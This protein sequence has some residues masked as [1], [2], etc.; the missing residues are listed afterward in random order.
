MARHL[1]APALFYG[2]GARLSVEGLERLPAGPA[3]LVAN[4]QSIIDVPVLFRALP[5]GLHFIVK[6]ELRRVPFL[7]W[8]IAAT[9][10]IFV[11]RRAPA[12]AMAEMRRAAALLRGGATVVSFPEGTRSRNGALAAF[13][14]AAF[15]AAIEAGVPV[16]PVAIVGTRQVLPPDGFRVRPGPI[17]VM[18]GE[19][20]PTRGL[21]GADRSRLAG[22]AREQVLELLRAM[23]SGGKA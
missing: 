5:V 4:H 20:I 7:G 8:Y 15:S 1:W 21:T 11:D 22:A 13:K 6:R 9:G 12:D 3:F 18:V 23:S 10:M 19:P 14:S 17:R 2:A 16:V